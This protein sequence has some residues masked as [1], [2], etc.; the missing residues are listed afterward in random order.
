MIV[1]ATD[2]TL[3]VLGDLV[4]KALTPPRNTN[5]VAPTVNHKGFNRGRLIRFTPYS[6]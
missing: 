1:F 2:K 3:L 6:Y 5:E 4:D